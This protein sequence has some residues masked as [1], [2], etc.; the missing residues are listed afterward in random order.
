MLRLV[1]SR[2]VAVVCYDGAE[3]LEIACVTA[4][5]AL[6]NYVGELTTPYDV[7]ILSPGGRAVACGPGVVLN[8]GH[9][10]EQFASPLD[11][12]VVAGG[13][14]YDAAAADPVIVAHV[15][16]LARISRRV[17]SVCTGAS[18]LAE[19]GLLD[20]AR[21]TTHWAYAARIAERYPQVT[22]DPGPI[23]IRDGNI[24]TSAGITSA[25]DLMLSLIQE[26]H[27]Q[28]LARNVS[29]HLVTYLQR[30]GTQAQMSVFTTA[31]PVDDDVIRR[32]VDHIH[33]H[34]DGD[35]TTTGLAGV[36]QVSVRH[37]NRLFVEHLGQ[38]PGR[39]IREAR[40]TA[41]AQ[42]LTTSTV[43]LP[44]IAARCGFGSAETLRVAFQRRFGMSPSRYRIVHRIVEPS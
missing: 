37:L 44:G 5:F 39:F 17:A 25:L 9:G 35:L 23:Y 36:A 33:T 18:I 1:P 6:A 41:A 31:P 32:L 2:S 15:R 11:T 29:R 42:L 28:A 43:H 27:G 16:R 24:A 21:A 7:V 10:L 3:L 38:T 19:A 22:F 12:L 14:S 8:S 40:L 34:L 26:D 30:P 13:P 4:T 20:G